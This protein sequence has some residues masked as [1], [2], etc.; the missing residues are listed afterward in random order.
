MAWRA[1]ALPTPS[2]RRAIGGQTAA[3]PP[4]CHGGRDILNLVTAGSARYEPYFI[5]EAIHHPRGLS[6]PGPWS[7]AHGPHLTLTG[8]GGYFG[9]RPRRSRHPPL[10]LAPDLER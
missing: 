6:L 2:H 9:T 7:D 3:L 4:H 5:P 1:R 10:P 8:V